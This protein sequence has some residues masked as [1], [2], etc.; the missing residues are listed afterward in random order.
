[1]YAIVFP[2]RLGIFPPRA[3][4]HAFARELD[5]M[6]VPVRQ[7]TITMRATTLTATDLTRPLRP[8]AH[9]G[10]SLLELLFM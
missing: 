2:C 4:W 8:L 10:K 6:L 3:G 7:P 9:E 5:A 1:M